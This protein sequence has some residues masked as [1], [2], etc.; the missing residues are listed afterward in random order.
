[1]PCSAGA[2][3]GPSST[4]PWCIGRPSDPDW[5]R[6]E[7]R[8]LGGNIHR[9]LWKRGRGGAPASSWVEKEVKPGGN[10]WQ[11]DVGKELCAPAL[12]LGDL[13]PRMGRK[14]RPARPILAPD[15][16]SCTCFFCRRVLTLAEDFED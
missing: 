5:R 8:G 9:R 13:G 12:W 15:G 1:M 2:L 16:L 7:T 4:A 11:T 10:G 3:W 6:E 14:E